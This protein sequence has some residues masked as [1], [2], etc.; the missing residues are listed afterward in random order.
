VRRGAD[1]ISKRARIALREQLV[2]TTVGYIDQEFQA[3]EIALDEAYH[4]PE[5]GAR[6]GRVEQYYRT[7]DF[8]AAEDARR[9]LDVCEAFLEGTVEPAKNPLV[10]HLRRDGYSFVDGRFVSQRPTLDDAARGTIGALGVP[11]V[12]EAWRRMF[13]RAASDPEGAITAA[14]TLMETVCKHI[15]DDLG[16]GGDDAAELPALYRA[17]STKLNLAPDQH[18]E[19]VFKQILGGCTT[20]VIGLAGVRNKLSDAHGKGPRAAR[21]SARHAELAVNLA[22][23]MAAFLVATWAARRSP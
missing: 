10:E 3:A 12:D 5:N 23:S 4:P 14:R 9:F 2:G 17:V 6:R 20:V 7:M 15:L 13:A 19:Q 18:T 11:A 1:L 8:T 22:G 16:E 21:P